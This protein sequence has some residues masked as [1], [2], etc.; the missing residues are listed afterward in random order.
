MRGQFRQ[1][2]FRRFRMHTIRKFRKNTSSVDTMAIYRG[3]VTVERK[4]N[5]I[6]EATQVVALKKADM[7]KRHAKNQEMYA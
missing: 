1:L 5:E 2:A 4:R 7:L 3:L 6:A